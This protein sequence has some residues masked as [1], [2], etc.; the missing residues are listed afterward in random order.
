MAYVV[1]IFI[2]SGYV[3]FAELVI[4]ISVCPTINS[5]CQGNVSL[6]N[7]T[8]NGSEASFTCAKGYVIN[9]SDVIT[10][11]NKT[12]SAPVP[13]CLIL[14]CELPPVPPNGSVRLISGTTTYG[15]V[16]VLACN[17]GYEPSL[18]E[19]SYC[20]VDGWTNSTFGCQIKSCPS[21]D[22]LKIPNGILAPTVSNI[23]DYG[24]TALVT[25]NVGYV[26][27]GDNV[28]VCD[29]DSK[30]RDHGSCV[31]KDCGQPV[32]NAYIRLT[33]VKTTF[34]SIAIARCQSGYDVDGSTDIIECGHD[35][36][37][38]PDIRCVKKAYHIPEC[39]AVD[40]P[41]N[42]NISFSNGPFNGSVG[43]L[44]C[45]EGYKISGKQTITCSNG[46]WSGQRPVCELID[47]GSPVPTAKST[48]T[49]G[50]TKVGSKA[51]MDCTTGY[52]INGATDTMTCRQ[53]G[54]WGPEITCFKTG[55]TDL[56]A[57]NNGKYTF[58]ADK[59]RNK[60]TVTLACN[61][62]YTLS[63]VDSS[64]CD[65][66]WSQLGICEK[67]RC[68]TG[69]FM[70]IPNGAITLNVK[71]VNDYGSTALV[72]CNVGY[73]LMGES[74]TT[75][76]ADKTWS[77][78]G[79]CEKC[80][81]PVERTGDY[82]Q[83]YTISGATVGGLIVGIIVGV[84]SMVVY[85]RRKSVVPK[86]G[87]KTP[88]IASQNHYFA[89]R[90]NNSGQ[91]PMTEKSKPKNEKQQ[92]NTAN[93]QEDSH[94]YLELQNQDNARVVT[95]EIYESAGGNSKQSNDRNEPL[96]KVPRENY[97]NMDLKN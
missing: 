61:N 95:N 50:E 37:W 46:T 51:V 83:A 25:C 41:I 23:T 31:E 7:G 32:V 33:Y 21:G 29:A 71:D 3:F 40:P 59:I 4:V 93:G 39:P 56:P 11:K 70:T 16:A 19:Y 81:T 97:I 27:S 12:W 15:S 67:I 24:S 89:Q 2:L 76:Q 78:H 13:V 1:N 26:V 55:C 88:E 82:P 64:V 66:S 84:G 80:S 63:G 18:P 5:P 49:Y 75:C 73:V 79:T 54:T 58:Y 86:S 85:M 10:C 52:E 42:G 38:R 90:G 8:F 62:G 34:R 36:F 35:G 28:T 53:N 77:A 17:T 9:G 43:S 96:A 45:K 44:A 91:S 69:D 60:T 68:P 92:R 94:E 74:I 20:D 6:V 57:M 30:W 65:G 48:V 22:W 14:D 47:C 87:S 72:A